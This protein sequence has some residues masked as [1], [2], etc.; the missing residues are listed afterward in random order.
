[1]TRLYHVLPPF[2]HFP[3]EQMTEPSISVIPGAGCSLSQCLGGILANNL[4]KNVFLKAM[5]GWTGQRLMG[6]MLRVQKHLTTEWQLLL[7]PLPLRLHSAVKSES[8]AAKAG[9]GLEMNEP[10][11]PTPNPR[12]R[13][14]ARVRKMLAPCQNT[15]GIVCRAQ[16]SGKFWPQNA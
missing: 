15:P 4:V 5:R 11:S 2:C 10:R 3:F 1:M 13:V 6:H 14:T 12:T 16:G 7:V 9:A 8:R